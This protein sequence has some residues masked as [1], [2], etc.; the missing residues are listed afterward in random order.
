[1][2]HMTKEHL[3]CR[4]HIRVYT[5]EKGNIITVYLYHLK[6]RSFE[7]DGLFVV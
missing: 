7:E 1:M 2:V 4:E 5:E 3:S 6:Q